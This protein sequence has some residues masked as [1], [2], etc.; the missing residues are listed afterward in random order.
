MKRVLKTIFVAAS[1]LLAGLILILLSVLLLLI[2]TESGIFFPKSIFKLTEVETSII[3]LIFAIHDNK[4]TQ[5][6]HFLAKERARKQ[7]ECL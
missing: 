2:V 1:S 4:K 3:I 7:Q 6:T 5:I